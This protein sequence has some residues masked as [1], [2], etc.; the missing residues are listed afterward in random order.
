LNS[1]VNQEKS[2]SGEKLLVELRPNHNSLPSKG[3]RSNPMA[4]RNMA[5]RL[6]KGQNITRTQRVLG[7]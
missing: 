6:L 5:R 3:L 2:G 7:G 1:V 4:L